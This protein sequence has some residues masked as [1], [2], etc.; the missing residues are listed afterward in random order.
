VSFGILGNLLGLYPDVM[1]NQN[2]FRLLLIGAFRSWQ[3]SI[4]K[5]HL[6]E[7]PE[8]NGASSKNIEAG[9]KKAPPGTFDA[10]DSLYGPYWTGNSAKRLKLNTLSMYKSYLQGNFDSLINVTKEMLDK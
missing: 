5:A 10:L 1:R 4:I 3:S 7:E 6:K 8:S 2:D 9:R